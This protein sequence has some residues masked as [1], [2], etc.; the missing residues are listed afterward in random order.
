MTYPLTVQELVHVRHE[1]EQLLE[2]V[3]EWNDDGELVFTP[4]R[5]VA[6]VN[7]SRITGNLEEQREINTRLLQ[8]GS[9]TLREGGMPSFQG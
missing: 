2:P 3:P 1:L 5:V 4:L 6:G 8:V 7:R 9:V